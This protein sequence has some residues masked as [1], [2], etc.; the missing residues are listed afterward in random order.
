MVLAPVSYTMHAALCRM[1][2]IQRMHRGKRIACFRN[3]QYHHDYP[4]R[5]RGAASPFPPKSR[6]TRLID[7]FLA[8]RDQPLN[9]W[10]IYPTRI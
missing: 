2:R 6:P 10:V 1:R 8:C 7:C 3:N 5:L 4:F 9:M